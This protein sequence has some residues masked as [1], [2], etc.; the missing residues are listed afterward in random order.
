MHKNLTQDIRCLKMI[1]CGTYC[2]SPSLFFFFCFVFFT[3]VFVTSD[4]IITVAKT[5]LF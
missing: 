4:L 1:D 3:G 5:D 2:L